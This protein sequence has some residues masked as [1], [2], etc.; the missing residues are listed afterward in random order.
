VSNLFFLFEGGPSIFRAIRP[1]VADSSVV[2]QR[3]RAG[4]EGGAVSLGDDGFHILYAEHFSWEEF[5]LVLVGAAAVSGS[6]FIVEFDVIFHGVQEKVDAGYVV[7]V[8]DPEVAHEAVSSADQANVGWERVLWRAEIAHDASDVVVVR[9]QVACCFP[10]LV[11]VLDGIGV[12]CSD[13]LEKMQVQCTVVTV[14][15]A[16]SGSG[17]VFKGDP[18]LE[19][20]STKW[21]VFYYI[22]TCMN[23]AVVEALLVDD[24]DMGSHEAFDA[25]F[26]TD[27][28]NVPVECSHPVV[29]WQNLQDHA[30]ALEHDILEGLAVGAGLGGIQDMH[31]VVV[32]LGIALHGADGRGVTALSALV[33]DYDNGAGAELLVAG[34]G[35]G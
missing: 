4:V 33:C 27:H 13:V 14:L 18:V 28:A 22:A 16:G 25:A 11:A 7:V 19:I 9:V 8:S 26:S 17:L 2:Q 35:Y 30:V 21:G 29:V 12:V 15:E 32:L 34:D 1:A 20:L 10:L 5:R 3:F 24:V 31:A 6:V 23:L